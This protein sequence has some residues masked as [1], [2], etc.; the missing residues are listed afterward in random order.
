MGA[1]TSAYQIEG[2]VSEDGRSESVWDR[3]ASTPGATRNGDTGDPA[4]DH[5]HRWQSDIG[6]MREL[7]IGAYRFSVSWPRVVP[8]GEGATNEAGIGFYDRLVDGLLAAGI[9]PF[10]TLYHWDH[11]QALEDKGGWRSREMVPAFAD[12]AA[13]VVERLGDRVT[14]WFTHNEPWVVAHL[15]HRTGQHAPGLVSSGSELDVAHH[16]LLSHGLAS[17]AMR[18][19]RSDVSVG[20]TLNLEPREPRSTHPL[21]VAA[22]RLDE[23]L[24]NEWFLDPLTGGGYPEELISATGWNE[25]VVHDGDLEVIAQPIDE[26]GLNYYR[27]EWVSD[28]SVSDEQRP[29]PLTDGPDEVSDMGWPVTPEGLTQMLRMLDR[30]GFESIYVTENGGAFPDQTT[31]DDIVQDDDRVS[32]FERHLAR[33]LEAIDEGIP[34]K[35]FFLW[36]LF[37]NF[38]WSFGYERRFGI[39]HVDFETQARTPK[40][41][42]TWY[43]DTIARNGPG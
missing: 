16:L 31:L 43:R 39:V 11:P 21:D 35:G 38:E 40:R 33:A 26:L 23:G 18:A 1:A 17:Q 19:Q 13:V 28:P 24:M 42:A 12:Y 7:G 4:C 36:S 34:L 10:V 22:A 15:G 8:T 6:L 3:F 32:Y 9:E 30:Y 20:I 14:H 29:L 2:V 25:S 5:Y 41:S 27:V 37:D